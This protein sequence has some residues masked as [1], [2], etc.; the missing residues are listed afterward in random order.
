MFQDW[1]ASYHHPFNASR[2]ASFLGNRGERG[3]FAQLV[4][5]DS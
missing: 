2:K 4:L 3:E 5:H 1:Q